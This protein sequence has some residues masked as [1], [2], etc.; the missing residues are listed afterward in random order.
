[1]T[2]VQGTGA[3]LARP[4]GTFVLP[5]F[6]EEG[7]VGKT[8]QALDQ[9]AQQKDHFQWEIIV[10]NDGSDDDTLGEATRIAATITTPV[11]I[12][13]HRRNA[14]LGAGMRTG[15]QASRGDVVLAVDCD[16]SYSIDDISRL[17]DTWAETHPHIVIASPY[18]EGGASV[19]VPRPLAMR[20]QAANKFLN[21]TSYHDIKTLTGMVRAYDGPFIRSMSLKAEGPDIMV[22]IIYKAQILRARIVEIPATLSWAGLEQRVS[23]SALTSTTSRMT[24]Y[25]QLIN[26]YLWRPFWV[27]LIP[28]LL[29]GLVGF[30]LTL[31]GH[32]GWHGVAVASS[33]LFFVLLVQSL[34]SLQ[35]KRYFEELY[36]LGYSLK[37]VS[38]TEPI[39]TP[40]V[41]YVLDEK[42]RP[43]PAT[44]DEVDA[45]FATAS[46]PVEVVEVAVQQG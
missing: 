28:A 15:I 2:T 1:M 13:S 35:S 38:P 46:T 40:S 33:V 7:T 23:R 36:N 6:R 34:M 14:G 41:E 45:A 11:R 39:R 4:T 19:R 21:F 31:T 27:P 10:V 43:T 29:F 32:L 37:A 12:L 24:T 25:R 26:G 16:L 9:L 44:I 18:M 30:V 22:E 8:L 42:N 5:C 20:S 3:Q 17:I